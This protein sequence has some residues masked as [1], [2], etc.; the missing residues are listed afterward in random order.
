MQGEN[1]FIVPFMERQGIRMVDRY[2]AVSEQSKEGLKCLYGR[3]EN[4]IDVVWH[5]V[6]GSRA[7]I[8]PQDRETIRTRMQLPE[9]QLLLFVGRVDDPRKNL[10]GLIRAMA[11]LPRELDAKLLVVGSGSN[12]KAKSLA[13]EMN[14]DERIF[15]MGRVSPE[16]LWSTYLVADGLV[17]VSWQEGFGLTIIEALC[18]GCPVIST[19]VGVAPDLQGRLEKVVPVNDEEALAEAI[20]VLF[21]RKGRPKVAEVVIP[22]ELSWER[23][24]METVAGYEKAIDQKHQ[25]NSAKFGEG[26]AISFNEN[27]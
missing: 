9:G 1:G 20:S 12:A 14:L 22:Y 27:N 15:F 23:C 4:R 8:G 19:E 16:D 10:L 13:R 2:L 6:D 11:S 3:P 21:K 26:S 17:C 24:A 18:A 5:G 25:A 7:P